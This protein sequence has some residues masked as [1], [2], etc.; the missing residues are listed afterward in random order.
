MISAERQHGASE[1]G[2]AVR[3]SKTWIWCKEMPVSKSAPSSLH[4]T[5]LLAKI[6]IMIMTWHPTTN[7]SMNRP[8]RR[9]MSRSCGAVSCQCCKQDDEMV[10]V[11]TTSSRHRSHSSRHRSISWSYYRHVHQH[12]SSGSMSNDRYTD[13]SCVRSFVDDMYGSHDADT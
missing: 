9:A 1:D 7:N 13:C 12:H 2:F 4:C 5:A 10:I 8:Y 6:M 3:I 11:I